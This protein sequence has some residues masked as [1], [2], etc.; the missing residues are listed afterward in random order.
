MDREDF[1]P[2]RFVSSR[3]ARAVKD[4]SAEPL[5]SSDDSHSVSDMHSDMEEELPV[6]I[7]PSKDQCRAALEGFKPFAREPEKQKRYLS[8]FPPICY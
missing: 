7:M 3:G 5:H 6:P 2:K 8:S 4:P 1:E